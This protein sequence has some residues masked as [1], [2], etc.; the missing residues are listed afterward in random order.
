MAYELNQAGININCTPVV[1]LNINP[2]C[3]I[4]GKV[5]RSFGKDA[6]V[7]HKLAS[8]CVREHKRN[9]VTCVYKHFPGHG[10]S[11]DDSHLGFTDVSAT[12]H[13]SELLPYKMAI[14]DGLLEMVMTAHVYNKYLDTELPFSLSPA[15]GRLLR[16]QLDFDNVIITDDLDMKSISNYYSF[17]EI[18]DLTTT[19]ETDLILFSNYRDFKTDLP[20]LYNEYLL[21]IGENRNKMCLIEKSIMR[22]ENIS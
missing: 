8:I 6:E 14:K 15:V 10:S 22:I 13:E 3:P 7:V 17:N 5:Q 2:A 9:N 21:K 19:N 16:K 12:W 20:Y 18:F 11:R 1:D 4:I